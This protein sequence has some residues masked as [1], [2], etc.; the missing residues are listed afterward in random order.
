MTRRSVVLPAVACLLAVSC[1]APPALIVGSATGVDAGGY[2]FRVIA[3]EL[4]QSA[5]V[6]TEALGTT[7]LTCHQRSL[8]GGRWD[9]FDC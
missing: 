6:V 9:D 1:A 3:P 5:G 7:N 8:S 4:E 2:T